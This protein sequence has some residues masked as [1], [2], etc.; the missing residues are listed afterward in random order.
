MPKGANWEKLEERMA[1]L[2]KMDKARRTPGS[3][4]TKGEEDVVGV[5]TICQCKDSDSKNISILT[6]DIERLLS[7]AKLL[8]KMPLFASRSAEHTVLSIPIEEEYTEEIIFVINQLILMAS[9]ALI[10]EQLDQYEGIEWVNAMSKE[11]DRVA[12]LSSYNTGL[13]KDRIKKLKNKMEQKVL[14][15]TTYNLFDGV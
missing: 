6:K 7:S 11:F 13:L 14:N 15:A 4:N 1:D 8:N 12:R 2:L 10:E 9:L 5:A 3:G